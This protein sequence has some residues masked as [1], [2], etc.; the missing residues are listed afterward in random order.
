MAKTSKILQD[1]TRDHFPLTEQVVIDTVHERIH[2]GQMFAGSV[3]DLAVGAGADLEILIRV[4]GGAHFRPRLAAGADIS[5]SLFEDPTTSADGTPVPA[6][7]RN[8]FSATAAET[9]IF[10]GPTVT[11][12]GTLLLSNFVPGGSGFLSGG[13]SDD[14]LEWILS[15]GDYLGR[16][17]NEST[18]A[19]QVAIILDWYERG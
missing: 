10:S 19:T 14:F 4:A 1:T 18:G 6:I 9:L 2:G 7:N 17:T 8:R 13:G 16:I 15:P 3:L 5:A 11:V 12:D